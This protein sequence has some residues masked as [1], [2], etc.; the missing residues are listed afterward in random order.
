MTEVST[1]EASENF[2]TYLVTE[3]GDSKKTLEA[4]QKDLDDFVS[5]VH[6]KEAC[7]L[8]LNDAS[9][10]IA[11]LYE[12]NF[13]R[14]TLVRKATVIRGFY[15]FLKGEQIIDINLSEIEMPKR[16][17]HLPTYLT[18]DEIKRLISVTE[19]ENDRLLFLLVA[20]CL[21]SGL[22]VSELVNLRIDNLN[23]TEGYIKIQ[24]K[25]NKERIIP[26]N[27]DL[28]ASVQDYLKVYRNGLITSNKY[29]FFLHPDGK[30]VSRQYFFLKI[31]ELAKKAN[32]N[33][34]ISPHTL[35]H[36]Y[37]TLLLNNGAKLKEVQELLGHAQIE[38]TEIY[39]HVSNQKM[40]EKYDEYMDR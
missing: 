23:L 39:T 17:R 13:A 36:T 14:R 30:R 12:K 10:F 5:F 3:K 31:K 32:I 19:G 34:D 21:S 7:H 1:K 2:L 38:T 22:R 25:G 33:K 28:K 29:L 9:D 27:G 8:A 24:G 40:L 20:I 26:L 4:Y 35:R 37:A 15:K 11:S 18:L 16:T 6:N